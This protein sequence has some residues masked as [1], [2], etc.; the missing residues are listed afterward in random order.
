MKSYYFTKH[1]YKNGPRALRQPQSMIAVGK[2]APYAAATAS[3]QVWR[4]SPCAAVAWESSAPSWRAT[5]MEAR[6]SGLV[7]S[8]VS[9]QFANVE[10]SGITSKL[11]M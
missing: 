6:A 1:F 3:E 10:M 9:S 4:T 11:S 8:T 7:P 2:R 5:V